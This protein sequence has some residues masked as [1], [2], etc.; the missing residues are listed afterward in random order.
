MKL[1]T[2]PQA[3]VKKAD[4]PLEPL[5]QQVG[6]GAQPEMRAALRRDSRPDRAQE[7]QEHRRQFFRIG[8]RRRKTIT[9]D[10]V[11]EREGENEPPA[12]KHETFSS[13]FASNFFIFYV[14]LLL[15]WI[16]GDMSTVVH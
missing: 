15:Y 12:Q 16:N 3:F 5:R 1:N 11:D 14:P 8:H 9:A 6:Q 2:A 4:I 10:D 13:I 7:D